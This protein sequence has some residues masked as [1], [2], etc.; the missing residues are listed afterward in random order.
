MQYTLIFNWKSVYCAERIE[1]EQE[2]TCL[3]INGWRCARFKYFLPLFQ[4]S[5]RPCLNYR[6]WRHL[7]SAT[8]HWIGPAIRTAFH[9]SLAW[10]WTGGWAM[11]SS[12]FV[13]IGGRIRRSRTDSGRAM[14]VLKKIVCTYNIII[15]TVKNSNL[16][17][18][19]TH[20]KVV[21]VANLK[22]NPYIYLNA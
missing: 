4:M 3:T 6:H 13:L 15:I 1:I 2:I 19:V 14:F 12:I 7:G 16:V 21:V 11:R 22:K 8:D 9:R 18:T 17:S 5:W 10:T 20:T